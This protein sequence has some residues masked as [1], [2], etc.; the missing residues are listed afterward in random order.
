[1]SARTDLASALAV[2]FP[3]WDVIPSPGLPDSID[4]PTLILYSEKLRPGPALGTRQAELVL[5]L[6]TEYTMDNGDDQGVED[7][8]DRT[9]ALLLAALETSPGLGWTEAERSQLGDIWPGYRVTVTLTYRK[10]AP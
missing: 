2:A 7:E 5:W 6:L 4:G 10:D 1:M 3:E 9:S 8:L